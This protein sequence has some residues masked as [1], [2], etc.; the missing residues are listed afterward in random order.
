MCIGE[1]C[2]HPEGMAAIDSISG[3]LYYVTLENNEGSDF[4]CSL[5]LSPEINP[6]VFTDTNEMSSGPSMPTGEG[7]AANQFKVYYVSSDQSYV[8]SN[9]DYIHAE[10]TEL[11]ILGLDQNP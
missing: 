3:D 7:S 2:V 1:D 5:T 10:Q 4:V 6:E 8:R 9:A 11:Q